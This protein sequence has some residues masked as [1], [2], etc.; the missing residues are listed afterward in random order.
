VV[1]AMASFQKPKVPA[2]AKDLSPEIT[3]LHSVEYQ[4]P[5]QLPQ[6]GVLIVGGGNSGAEIA[7]E[8]ARRGR[9]VWMSGRDT[10]AV[11]VRLENAIVHRLWTPIMLRGIFHRLLTLK[12]PMGR[13]MRPKVTLHGHPLIRVKPK[14]LAAVGVERV[15]RTESVQHGKPVLADGRAMDVK[16]VIFCTGFHAGFSWI[17]LPLHHENGEPVH[18]RGVVR[19]LP[20]LYFVGL[21]FLYAMSSTMIHGVGRDAEY[22]ANV[23]SKRVLAAVA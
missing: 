22:V 5:S 10:G 20:G 2:F 18:D 1:V 3:Q 13:K 19:D 11:P 23:V 21:Q 15:P 7:I 6:G 4:R 9:R 8:L 14:D 16:S 12:T 17:D